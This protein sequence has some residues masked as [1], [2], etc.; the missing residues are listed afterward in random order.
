MTSSPRPFPPHASRRVPSPRRDAF[1]AG[2]WAV[3]LV[4]GLWE[5]LADEQL[6]RLVLDP[7]GLMASVAGMAHTLIVALFGG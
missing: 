7:L 6:A 1:I 2:L 5:A 4:V 3:A